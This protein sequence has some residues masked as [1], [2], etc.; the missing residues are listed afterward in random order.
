MKIKLILGVLSAAVLL[1][2]VTLALPAQTRPQPAS[3]SQAVPSKPL[4]QPTIVE[5][6]VTAIPQ[7]SSDTTTAPGTVKAPAPTEF[8]KN[9]DGSIQIPSTPENSICQFPYYQVSGG[10]DQPTVCALSAGYTDCHN[11]TA[12]PD[13]Q[14]CDPSTAPKPYVEP[15]V[16]Q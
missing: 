3:A 13:G 14:T 16:T 15:E 1:T 10:A 7:H 5:K 6:P 8:V 11:N 4:A 9:A 12:V 2:G